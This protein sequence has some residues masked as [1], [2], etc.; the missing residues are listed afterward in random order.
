MQ[1]LGKISASRLQITMLGF[2]IYSPAGG[3]GR[4]VELPLPDD[5]PGGLGHARPPDQLG[6]GCRAELPGLLLLSQVGE[7]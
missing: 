3:A 4:S 1:T 7:E 5:G 6:D 2:L